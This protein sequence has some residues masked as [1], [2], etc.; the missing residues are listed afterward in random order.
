MSDYSKLQVGKKMRTLTSM[1]AL[2][3]TLLFSHFASA[4]ELVLTCHFPE[5][6]N[7]EYHYRERTATYTINDLSIKTEGDIVRNDYIILDGGIRKIDRH[8][9]QIQVDTGDGFMVYGHCQPADKKKF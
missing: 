3:F 2:S 6:S 8:T 1:G 5:Q 7:A 4:F 9:G